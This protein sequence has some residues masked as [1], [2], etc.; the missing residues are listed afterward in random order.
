MSLSFS[1]E[2]RIV[3]W[4]RNGVEIRNSS[5]QWYKFKQIQ[6]DDKGTYG[7]TVALK[8][9]AL[10]YLSQTNAAIEVIPRGWLCKCPCPKHILRLNLT[11]EQVKEK[12]DEIKRHLFLESSSLSKTVRKKTSA[13]DLRPLS[14]SLGFVGISVMDLVFGSFML[15]DLISLIY[16]LCTGNTTTVKANT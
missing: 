5:S 12:V 7:C 1:K 14:I 13:P 11:E 4:L 10:K 9:K 8:G 16:Y 6:L 3:T 15:G 2:Q